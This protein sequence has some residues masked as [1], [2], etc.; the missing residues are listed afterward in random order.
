MNKYNQT[1]VLIL[2]GAGFIGGYLA[3]AL[4]RA[5]YQ[6]R[7][8]TRNRE[9]TKGGLII[10]QNVELLQTDIS[11]LDSL[12]QL[13]VGVDIVINCVGI[14]HE[15]RKGDFT[16]FHARFVEKIVS[17]CNNK[18]ISK[19]IHLSALKALVSAPSAYLRS[20]A[21]GEKIISE[22]L[23]K[24]IVSYILRPSVVFGDGDSFLSMFAKLANWLPLI[25]LAKPTAKFQ[26]IFVGD[27]TQAVMNCIN[28]DEKR[29]LLELCGPR[30][31]ELIELVRYATAFGRFSPRIIPLPDWA[32]QLQVRI[33]ELL[34]LNLITRDN[35][36]SMSIDNT[37]D[38]AVITAYKTI[39][40]I[41]PSYLSQLT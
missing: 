23:Q 11:K 40:S 32:A 19:L 33:L 38:T 1:T 34:Q 2:G 39:E 15:T 3:H 5:G 9:R 35:L 31:Y 17:S 7:I 8:P 10:L 4:S 41:A 18:K 21:E 36:A 37:C 6:V 30:Q 20:K 25:P 16:K 27:V 28:G 26:P 22:T 14:L 12:D 24:S 29:L 13:F